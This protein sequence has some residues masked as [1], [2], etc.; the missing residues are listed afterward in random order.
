MNTTI[1]ANIG[2]K[3][4]EIS[5]L[6]PKLEAVTD[7]VSEHFCGSFFSRERPAVARE[8]ARKVMARQTDGDYDGFCFSSAVGNYGVK[9]EIVV[10]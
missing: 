2:G 1:I 3:E 9:I 7:F 6:K 8:I 4:I 5:S 10:S